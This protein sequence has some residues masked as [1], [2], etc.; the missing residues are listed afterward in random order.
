MKVEV[1]RRVG[2]RERPNADHPENAENGEGPS[3]SARD[4][5]VDA[6]VTMQRQVRTAATARAAITCAFFLFFVSIIHRTSRVV[7]SLSE[8]K[9][10]WMGVGSCRDRSGLRHEPHGGMITIK[11]VPEVPVQPCP[12]E[13]KAGRRC[14]RS[15]PGAGDPWRFLGAL[16]GITKKT[17]PR[18]VLRER[19]IYDLVRDKAVEQTIARW[20]QGRWRRTWSQSLRQSVVRDL[21]STGNL[22][23]HSGQRMGLGAT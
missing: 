20:R 3:D 6:L 13:F 15:A 10:W 16:A 19:S 4:R 18:V 1:E 7:Q 8:K 23:R 21:E 9:G 14:A 12:A 5:V 2:G 22:C 11:A 17:A